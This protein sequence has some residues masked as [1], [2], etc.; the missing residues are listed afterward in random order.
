MH[1]GILAVSEYLPDDSRSP[2]FLLNMYADEFSLPQNYI[3][4]V[5]R[6]KARRIADPGT[7]PS[8]LAILA[9][10]ECLQRSPGDVDVL[11]FPGMRR[12]RIEPATAHVI[13]NALNLH[14]EVAYD[15]SDACNGFGAALL[16]ADGY[17][18]AGAK[19][20]LIATG[21]IGSQA[22]IDAINDLRHTETPRERM[23]QIAASFTL[24][25]AGGAVIVGKS[26]H[27]ETKFIQNKSIADHS[28]HRICQIKGSAAPLEADLPRLAE[29]VREMAW[30]TFDLFTE[31]GCPRKKK[32]CIV[33]QATKKILD[34][35]I[36]LAGMPES[37]FVDIVSTLGNL[38]TAGW[39]VQ[40]NRMQ[41]KLKEGDQVSSLIVGS[42]I[43]ITMLNAKIKRNTHGRDSAAQ[44]NYSDV[45]AME[46]AT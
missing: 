11:L 32:Y 29:R 22:E 4:R 44:R 8:D 14:P 37:H 9:A 2:D 12:D 3:S 6:I 13:A 23:P 7:L 15:L 25:D 20:V 16:A 45:S 38:V 28:A 17:I 39:P 5:T 21:E 42:G 43:S 40:L 36:A 18:A 41:E 30:P 26:E 31:S 46:Q 24:G 33:H 27:C 1:S 10:K 35:M 34:E 19:R